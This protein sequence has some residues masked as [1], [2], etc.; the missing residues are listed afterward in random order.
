MEKL[1]IGIGL[2]IG[3]IVGGYLPVVLF[4]VSAFSWVS[5]ICGFVGCFVGLRL[6]WR[7]TLWIDE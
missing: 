2:M 1:T 7:L 6:G 3:S 4:H 5:L